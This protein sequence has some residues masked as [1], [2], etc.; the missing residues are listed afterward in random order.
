LAP[1]VLDLV[2]DRRDRELAFVRGDA[3]RLVGREL[4]AR[5]AYAGAGPP[6][7]TPA[8]APT[9]SAPEASAMDSEDAGPAGA[10]PVDGYGAEADE[11]DADEADP[12][13]PY[14]GDPA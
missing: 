4:D 14:E 8:S 2:A 5:R 11:A 7:P 6:A 9:S 13:P 12:D 3:Y 1:A 10:D